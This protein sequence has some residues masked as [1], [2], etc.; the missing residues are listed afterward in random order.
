MNSVVFFEDPSIDE[1][2]LAT[3]FYQSLEIQELVERDIP[4]KKPESVELLSQ[5]ALPYEP[6]VRILVE[7]LMWKSL[8]FY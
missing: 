8:A 4:K 5:A 1:S 6:E 2:E 3:L 7:Q